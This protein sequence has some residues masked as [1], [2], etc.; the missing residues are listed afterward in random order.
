[1]TTSTVST[2]SAA[3]PRARPASHWTDWGQWIALATMT[4]DHVVR[5]LLPEAWGMDWAS[6]SIGR[7][8]FP[9]FAAMVAWHGLFNTRD[10]MR[11]ARR[12]ML[13]G[14][15][16][17]LPYLTMPREAFQLNI[18]F[19]L[20]L[21]LMWGSGLRMIAAKAALS[22][23]F[24]GWA[25]LAVGASLVGWFLLGHWVEYT[26]L[27]LLFVPGY[28]LAFHV[29]HNGPPLLAGRGAPLLACLPV[30]AVAVTMNSSIMAKSFTVATTGL[31]LLL[32][33]GATRHVPKIPM[34]MPRRLWLAWYPAHFAMIAVLLH[35][36]WLTGW[37]A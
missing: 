19:A 33:A 20:A 28:M 16:A 35:W 32:A 4:V 17:Q 25:A 14:L 22:R 30:L 9:L 10:P 1:M 7:V 36:Q 8:A 3:G 31:M 37:M 11:Y 26:H 29:L 23:A 6:S 24:F 2:L 5:Y 18:C 34:R 27:G 12:I 21:S 15:F 13:I